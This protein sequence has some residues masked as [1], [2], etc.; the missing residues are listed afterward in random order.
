MNG[1]T[2]SQVSQ[3]IKCIHETLPESLTRLVVEDMSR[4]GSMEILGSTSSITP[5]ELKKVKK[6]LE[7][8]DKQE[9]Y[10]VC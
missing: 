1:R 5:M 6:A 9:D 3:Q 7:D 8:H 2:I 10:D 4:V